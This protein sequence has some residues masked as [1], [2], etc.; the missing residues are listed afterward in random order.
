MRRILGS[1]EGGSRLLSTSTASGQ[2]LRQIVKVII[3][4][5][6]QFAMGRALFARLWS[7]SHNE[8]KE[9]V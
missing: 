5:T 7:I 4:P 8:W 1:A 3:P 6:A 9:G 2:F